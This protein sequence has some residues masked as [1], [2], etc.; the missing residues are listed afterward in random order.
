MQTETK[1][2]SSTFLTDTVNFI[3]LKRKTAV[4]KNRQAKLQTMKMFVNERHHT[5]NDAKT[6]LA[7]VKT[8]NSNKC[9]DAPV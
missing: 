6:K 7:N 3:K 5:G 1:I 2:Q 4:K 8:T 9:N